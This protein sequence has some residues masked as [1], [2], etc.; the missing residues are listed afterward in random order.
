MDRLYPALKADMLVQPFS[1]FIQKF[2]EVGSSFLR[3]LAWGGVESMDD[4]LVVQLLG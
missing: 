4:I 2:L 3:V 1:R